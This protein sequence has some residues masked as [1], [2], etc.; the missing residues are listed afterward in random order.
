MM[1]VALYVYL[2][3]LVLYTIAQL[4]AG[5]FGGVATL[6]VKWLGGRKFFIPSMYGA[7]GMSLLW[8]IILPLQIH[9]YQMSRVRFYRDREK[10]RAD[11]RDDLRYYGLAPSIRVPDFER[12]R[13]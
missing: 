10:R 5:N 1:I 4:A 2:V 12:E 8:F 9:Q 6:T 3:G 7:L 11:Q 13:P